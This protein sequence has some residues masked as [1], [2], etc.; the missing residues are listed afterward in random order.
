MSLR[1]STTVPVRALSLDAILCLFWVATKR[2]Y[3]VFAPK[4]GRG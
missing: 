2:L 3:D 1:V 4:I